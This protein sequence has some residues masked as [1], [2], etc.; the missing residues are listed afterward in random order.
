VAAAEV[1]QHIAPHEV[2]D[3]EK[4]A[5]NSLGVWTCNSMH[6]IKTH[7]KVLPFYQIFDL[8]EIEQ[9]LHQ[10]DVVGRVVDDGDDVLERG[11]L[12]LRQH[13]VD[14]GVS[15][16][17]AVAFQEIV[18]CNLL[19][20]REYLLCHMLRRRSTVLTIEFDAEVLVRSARIV[21]RRKN[22]ASEAKVGI[23]VLVELADQSGDSWRRHETSLS[24]EQLSNTIGDSNL[25][26]DLGREIIVISSISGHNHCL[27][28]ILLLR[29]RIENRLHKVL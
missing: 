21:T 29:Q 18:V 24:N 22:D 19:C 12:Y 23:V 4:L 26:D 6:A 7:R 9:S 28:V 13:V 20:L 17:V 25:N 1:R 15:V 2:F 27:P 5:E 8:G 3:A 16:D 11:A 14:D 10:L